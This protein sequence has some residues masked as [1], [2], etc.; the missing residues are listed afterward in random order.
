MKYAAHTTRLLAFGKHWAICFV[1]VTGL[2]LLCFSSVQATVFVLQCLAALFG[3]PSV[4]G[5]T[6]SMV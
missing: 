3:M 6:G 2:A 4:G 5:P 1:V